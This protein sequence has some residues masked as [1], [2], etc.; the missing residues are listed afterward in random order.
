MQDAR[1]LTFPGFPESFKLDL[2]LR[3][4]RPPESAHGLRALVP[5]RRQVHR[6]RPHRGVAQVVLH[7]LDGHRALALPALVLKSA[8]SV[9]YVNERR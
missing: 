8:N 1:H 9:S 3:S 7:H 5:L 4:H 2:R 6:G